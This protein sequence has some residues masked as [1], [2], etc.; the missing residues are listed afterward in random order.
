MHAT[1][2]K[3]TGT[4]ASFTALARLAM[5]RCI[6]GSR[7][8]DT[9]NHRYLREASH[10]PRQQATA[11][12]ARDVF[13]FLLLRFAH[14][15]HCSLHG[16]SFSTFSTNLCLGA[17]CFIPC[18]LLNVFFFKVCPI[19][20]IP[21]DF[22]SPN[23]NVYRSRWKSGHPGQQNNRKYKGCP[24]KP[25]GLPAGSALSATARKQEVS[26]S[27]LRDCRPSFWQNSRSWRRSLGR[28][29]CTASLR[30]FQ[31]WSVMRGSRN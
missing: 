26:F 5:G 28:L 24:V 30:R 10:E 27:C 7:R 6:M 22:S 25:A 8:A 2:L 12:K 16:N 14:T 18:N 19:H 17:F 3:V 13:R 23:I 29:A 1:C 31:R 20:H 9:V 15:L 21:P 4:M 11:L